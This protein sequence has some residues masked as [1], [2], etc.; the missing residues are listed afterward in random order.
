MASRQRY[1]KGSLL[2]QCRADVRSEWVLRYRVTLPDGSRVQRQAI[3]GT[4]QKYKTESQAQKAA[5]Q[6]RLTINNMSPAVQIPTVGLVARHFKDVELNQSNTRRSWSTKTNYCDMLNLYILH[7]LPRWEKSLMLDIKTVAVEEWLATLPRKT[8]RGKPPQNAT[9]QRIRNV[10][11]V[12]FTHARR[13]EFVPIGHNPITLVRQSG[14]RSRIPDILTA[15]EINAIWTESEARE[16]AAISIEY[17]NGLRI[18]EAIGLKWSDIDFDEETASVNKSVVKGRVGE[19]K[20]E[21]SK[22]FVPL[23]PAQIE[24]LRAWREVAPYPEDDAWLFASHRTHGHKPYYPDMMLKRHIRC[25]AKKLG[26]EKHIG[27]HTFRRTYSSLLVANKENVK[28]VQELLRHATSSM[29]IGLYAQTFSENARQVQSKIV[30]MVRNAPLP[31]RPS[32]TGQPVVHT[33]Q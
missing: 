15:S 11:S 16:R 10:F 23:H 25:T 32:T 17:G 22:K 31:E 14:K 5:D 4:T 9:K 8:D 6:V 30:D 19:T 33:V 20:T 3:V 29:A 28:V 21:I 27:W 26:I 7:I 1:Q 18:S 13:H 2:R 12:L 24:A